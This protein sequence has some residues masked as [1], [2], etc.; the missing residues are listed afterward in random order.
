MASLDGRLTESSPKPDTGLLS[1][2]DPLLG[3]QELLGRRSV[4][5]R[6]HMQ[7]SA[8]VGLDPSNLSYVL[9]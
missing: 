9:L 7:N 8:F 6:T 2:Q 3:T 1:R 4:H 5:K